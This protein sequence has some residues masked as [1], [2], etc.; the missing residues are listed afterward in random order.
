MERTAS[1]V[2][3]VG[4]AIIFRGYGTEKEKGEDKSSKGRR[5]RFAGGTG[6]A[7]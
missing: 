1:A 7:R 2:R 6:C 4:D 5:A 3:D